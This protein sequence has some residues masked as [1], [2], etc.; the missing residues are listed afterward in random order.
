MTKE[1]EISKQE[2]PEEKVKKGLPLKKT[3]HY[4]RDHHFRN[5]PVFAAGDIF[6]VS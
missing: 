1:R 3:E 5:I 2:L 6:Y 4:H